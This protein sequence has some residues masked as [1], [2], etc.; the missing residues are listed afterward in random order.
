ALLDVTALTSSFAAAV[1]AKPAHDLRNS[2]LILAHHSPATRI[3]VDGAYARFFGRQAD[4]NRLVSDAGIGLSASLLNPAFGVA[5][6]ETLR[7]SWRLSASLFLEH[8]DRD[9]LIDPWRAV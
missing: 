2:V 9:Y 4:S 5:T 1:T 6:G 3:G 8:D 7:P